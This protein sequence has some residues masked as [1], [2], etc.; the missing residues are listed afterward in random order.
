M[1]FFILILIQYRA[2]ETQPLPQTQ[3]SFVDGQKYVWWWN[4]FH[5]EKI[6]RQVFLV[7]HFSWRKIFCLLSYFSENIFMGKN[8]SSNLFHEPFHRKEVFGH[9]FLIKH[10]HGKEN[11]SSRLFF[12][13]NQIF[14]QTFFMSK[15]SFVKHFPCRK[16]LSSNIFQVENIFRQT[17]SM[18]KKCF[19][20]H[21]SCRTKSFVRYF[22]AEKN[23]SSNIYFYI[24]KIISSNVH[25]EKKNQI[26]FYGWI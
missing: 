5:G 19:V 22:Y 9:I 14:R 10:F 18:S 20:K 26:L 23:L 7:K 16:N 12:I 8:I 11:L 25:G 6:S 1:G 21:F 17:F 4:F 2:L 15:R 13:S 3:L 24:A